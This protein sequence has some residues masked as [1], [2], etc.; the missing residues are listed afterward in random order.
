MTNGVGKVYLVG[1]GPGDPKLIT[2]KGAEV[3]AQADVIVYDRLASPVLLDYARKDAELIYVG[4]LPDRHIIPQDDINQIL[5]NQAQQGK[6]VVRLKGGDPS[7]FGRVGEEA[8]CCVQH[9]IPFE[10]IPGITSGIAAPMYAGI[11]LTH[12]DYNSTVA[13][14]TGHKRT[15][16]R[17]G[18]EIQW[19][20]ISTGIETLVFYM[21]VKNLPYIREQLMAHGRSP[22]TPVAL[23][24][25]GTLPGQET[26]VG[27][28]ENIVEKVE[29]AQFKPP[30][31]IV[32]GEVVHL[33][34]KL[35]WFEKELLNQEEEVITER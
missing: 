29:E 2:V 28:L 32:V 21:G 16:G 17:G 5:V 7:I 3:L 10:V 13:I 4:K 18:V 6:M 31:I 33:R 27:T 20:K 23:V 22:A 9:H 19:D 26:L 25:W 8:E 24:R 12:R 15:D 11:P 1:A 34:E 35:Q 14:I 30:A